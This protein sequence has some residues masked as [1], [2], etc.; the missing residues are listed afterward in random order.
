MKAA[1]FYSGI[2]AFSLCNSSVS[3]A[4]AECG[5]KCVLRC[6]RQVV[7]KRAHDY[8]LIASEASDRYGVQLELM[9]AMMRTESNYYPDA[10]SSKG[11]LGL[12]QIMPSTGKFL[13]IQDLRDPRQNIFGAA[14]FVRMLANAT[15]LDMVLVVAGY[16]AGL[17]AVRKSGGV[18]KYKST[19]KYV[20]A[21]TRRFFEFRAHVLRCANDSGNSI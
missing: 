5:R 10:V 3:S 11:A 14:K 1:K 16:H 12:M 13:N 7:P 18:P 4:H 15:D 6:M 21:V 8:L 2:L 20:R 9:M 19:R 17:G